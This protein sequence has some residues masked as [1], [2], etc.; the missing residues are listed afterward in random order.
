MNVSDSND[1]YVENV[2]NVENDKNVNAE[3]TNNTPIATIGNKLP[4]EYDDPVDLFFKKIID[5]INPFFKNWGFTPNMITTISLLFG[6]LACYL[7][8][9]QNYILSS[10]SFM[11]SYFFD[12]MDG[13]YARIYNMKSKFGA[14]YDIISDYFVYIIALYLFIVNKHI[15]N[16]FK[17]ISL[18]I[19]FSIYI[20][21]IF[22]FSCQEKYT[23]KEYASET[24][25]FLHF[26][27][28]HNYEIMRYTRYFG[29][30]GLIFLISLGIFSHKFF[31]E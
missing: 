21:T 15:N 30:G 18:V 8:Y 3:I 28:I 26:L 24:L 23:S 19:I 2:E 29:S 11:T 20:L 22:H 5:V 31:T 13:Y 25:K 10:F 27:P 16:N 1:K 4:P 12:V 14:Y 7:Y 17:S 9:K 6:L